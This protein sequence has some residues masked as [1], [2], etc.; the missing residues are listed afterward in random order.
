MTYKDYIFVSLR[1][2]WGAVVFVDMFWLLLRFVI[3][4]IQNEALLI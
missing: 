1:A 4:L 3:C 2:H